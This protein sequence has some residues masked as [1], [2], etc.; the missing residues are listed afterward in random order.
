MLLSGGP[1]RAGICP[2]YFR[3]CSAD[4]TAVDFQIEGP[5]SAVL[6]AA[7]LLSVSALTECRPGLARQNTAGY[8]NALNSNC[9][10]ILDMLMDFSS[11]A[12]RH[13]QQHVHVS[14][15]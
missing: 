5:L 4:I 7:V 2:I 1:Y 3:S 14:V 9:E 8:T 10:R 11:T 15:I 13:G 12:G 6:F